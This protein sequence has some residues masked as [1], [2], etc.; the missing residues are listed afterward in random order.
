MEK[1]MKCIMYKGKI[2]RVKDD[3]ARHLVTVKKEAK[4]VPKTE[5]KKL[6]QEPKNDAR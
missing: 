1:T 6:R 2:E 4:Y 3:L 5:W